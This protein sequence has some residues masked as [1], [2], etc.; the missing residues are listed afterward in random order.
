M[1]KNILDHSKSF[2]N[3]EDVE[4]SSVC[5]C[6][7]CGKI[8]SPDEVKDWV[9]EEMDEVTGERVQGTAV[10]PYCGID[11]VIAEDA[12]NNIT[13]ETLKATHDEYFNRVYR[14]KDTK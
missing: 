11:S 13:P 9:D 7:Y 1:S 10:C 6:F 4:M 3:L 14:P 12:N 8:F 5:G 2:H